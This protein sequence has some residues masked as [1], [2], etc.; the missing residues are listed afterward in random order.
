M[1]AAVVKPPKVRTAFHLDQHRVD[2]VQ[3]AYGGVWMQF[4]ADSPQGSFAQRFD[5]DAICNAGT[6]AEL[7]AIAD[8]LEGL[9]W[10]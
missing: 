9:E 10:V 7:H 5:F 8:H 3:G 1:T 2:V 4:W 6:A